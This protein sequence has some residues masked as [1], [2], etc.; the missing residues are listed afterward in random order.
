[1][2]AYHGFAPSAW[3]L[4]YSERKES[5][6]FPREHLITNVLLLSQRM[7]KKRGHKRTFLWGC[8]SGSQSQTSSRMC[9]TCPQEQ[10]QSNKVQ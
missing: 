10:R 3:T 1:M 4:S 2:G 6:V 7:F 9:P 5:N 8:S